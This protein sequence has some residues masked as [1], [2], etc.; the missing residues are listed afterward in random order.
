MSKSVQETLPKHFLMLVVSLLALLVDIF[1]K[2]C[3]HAYL[4]THV[5]HVFIPHLLNFI[6]VSNRGLAFSVVH[7]NGM[8]AKILSSG[9]FCLLLYLYC[10]R[11]L[12]DKAEHEY[13]EQL[14][15]SIIIGAAAGNLLER[16]IYGRVTDFLEFA[17]ITFPVFNLADVLIDVG[18]G[19]IFISVY[20]SKKSD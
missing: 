4:E 17:F 5:R 20:Q 15:M 19:L 13:F 10:R 1:T 11:Y 12:L 18:I 9:V 2:Y 7:D 14:G 6:L 3:A 8:L 16:F